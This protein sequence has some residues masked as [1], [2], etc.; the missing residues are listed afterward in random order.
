M[1]NGFGDTG[2]M[3]LVNPMFVRSV[4]TSECNKMRVSEMFIVG[5]MDLG[6]YESHVDSGDLNDYSDQYFKESVAEL[7]EQLKEEILLNE[8]ILSNLDKI[9][10]K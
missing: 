9:S 2:V 6:D 5:T 10:L 3:C 4:P 7:E 1:F 8:K